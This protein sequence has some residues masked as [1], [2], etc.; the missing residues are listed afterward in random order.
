[1]EK[2]ILIFEIDYLSFFL[3]RSWLVWPH[4]FFRQLVA[5]GGKRAYILLDIAPTDK[6][7]GE[8]T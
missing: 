2:E 8:Q 7:M 3:G 4:F 1:M 5:R 6:M